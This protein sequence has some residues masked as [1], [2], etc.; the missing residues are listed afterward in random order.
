M[1]DDGEAIRI[2]ESLI[3]NS[4][5]KPAVAYDGIQLTRSILRNV[6]VSYQENPQGSKLEMI[7]CTINNITAFRVSPYSHGS[8]RLIIRNSVVHNFSI[9]LRLRYDG[10]N[11]T[12]I[13]STVNNILIND[14]IHWLHPYYWSTWSVELNIINSI[15]NIGYI[16]VGSYRSSIFID[17]SSLNRIDLIANASVYDRDY[18]NSVINIRNTNF[19]NGSIQLKNYAGQIIYS[20]ITLAQPP[21]SITRS[22]M[23]ACSSIVRMTSIQQSS[24][25]GVMTKVL[26]MARSSINNFNV[27]LRVN[28]SSVGSVNITNCNFENNTLYNIDNDG[29]YHVNAARNWWGSSDSVV[30]ARKI[31]DYWDDIHFGIVFTSNYS[32]I[33]LGAE[34]ECPNYEPTMYIPISRP[35]F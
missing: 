26:Q 25:T 21:L 28:S 32:S 11:L 4:T 10:V 2:I 15:L 1:R 8:L 5:L 22:L 13:E 12:L 20:N 9:F 31:L 30:I 18:E 27:G 34:K 23:V 17:S 16:L 14:P 6:S 24:T 19:R 3:S 35:Y 33:K 7:N 29:P